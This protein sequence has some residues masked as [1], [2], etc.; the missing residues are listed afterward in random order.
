MA[1]YDDP[2]H[3]PRSQRGLLVV[4]AISEVLPDGDKEKQALQ[5]LLYGQP[6]YTGQRKL[7]QEDEHGGGHLPVGCSFFGP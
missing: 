7:F 6:S 1:L 3:L 2:F 4:Q 5:G